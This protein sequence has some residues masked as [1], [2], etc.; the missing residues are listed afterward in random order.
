MLNDV[1]SLN[2]LNAALNWALDDA[3]RQRQ[4]K[5]K[6]IAESLRLLK[7]VSYRVN[8]DGGGYCP[9]CGGREVNGEIYH[10]TKCAYA[11]Y[12]FKAEWS[13]VYPEDDNNVG[14]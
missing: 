4:E 14:E 11:T 5:D 1:K 6:L 8:G 3:I 9:F 10:A 2:R 12:K 7:L 13:L